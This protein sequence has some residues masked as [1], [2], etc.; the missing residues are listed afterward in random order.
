MT[1]KPRRFEISTVLKRTPPA[2]I[3]DAIAEVLNR[4]T[5]S[6]RHRVILTGMALQKRLRRT[7]L[8]IYVSSVRLT[9]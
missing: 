9:K 2:M 3:E 1:T 7:K 5:K 4:S 8:T 6:E